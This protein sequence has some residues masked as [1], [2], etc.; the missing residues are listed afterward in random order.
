MINCLSLC[1]Q[2]DLDPAQIISEKIV[3]N[4]EKYPVKVEHPLVK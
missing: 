1:N 4:A 3:K 2:L